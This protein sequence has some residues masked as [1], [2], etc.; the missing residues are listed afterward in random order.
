MEY[1][2]ERIAYDFLDNEIEISNDD[3]VGKLGMALLEMQKKMKDNKGLIEEKISEL[4]QGYIRIS[5]MNDQL[6]D[7]VLRVSE[8]YKET[9]IALANAI[10]ANDIYTRGHCER[11]S[12]YSLEIASFFNYDQADLEVLEYASLLHDIGKISVPYS[13]L[14][15]PGRLTEDEFHIIK[16]HPS[17]GADIV[18]GIEFLKQSASIIRQHHERVDGKGYPD[19][20]KGEEM[21]LSAKIL[22]V[23]DAFDAMTSSRPYRDNP[24]SVDEALIQ[25]EEH[26]GTQFSA[27]VVAVMKQ[28]CERGVF[29]EI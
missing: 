7:M 2:A 18:Q 16:S 29:D 8:N 11:V 21:E 24:L 1:I 27:E 3:E 9:V 14:N 20:I 6:E 5:Y 12:K 25:L 26:S 28:L 4:E 10:E 19:G 15:K 13:V 22:C 23:S 17:I